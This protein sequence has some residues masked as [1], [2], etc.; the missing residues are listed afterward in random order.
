MTGSGATTGTA[1]ASSGRGGSSG[2]TGEAG[3]GGAIGTAGTSARA[4]TSG[5]T[6][7]AGTTGAAG[8]TGRAGTTGTTGTA[9]GGGTRA[10]GGSSGTAGTGAAGSRGGSGGAGATGRRERRRGHGGHDRH[11]GT[12]GTGGA[13][14][15]YRFPAGSTIYQDVSG[16]AVDSESTTILQ[17][18]QTSGW[19][20]GLGID[21]SITILTADASVPRRTFVNDGDDPDCDSAPV[22]LPAG[23]NIEGN[24]NYHCADGGDCHLL[25]YQGT[26]LYELY[27]A[28]VTTG[29]ATGGTFSGSC[30]VVWDLTRDYWQP[31]AS[32]NFSRGDHCNGADAAD[33]PM[34]A[35]TLTAA[36]VTSGELTH[37]LRFT[38]PNAH[39]RK[40]VYVHPA[41]HI[42]GPTGGADQIPYGARLR[43]K[44]SYDVNQL[45]SAA[46][47][48]IAR[49]LQK[50][51]M[52]MSDGGNLYITATTDVADVVST[53]SLR[54]LKAT[55]FE[56]VDG[57][58][59]I[60]WSDYQCH[61]TVVSN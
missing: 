21:V 52:I 9:G 5:T 37:A 53:G 56:M 11:G 17:A 49:G 23:G 32:P 10:R 8:A 48:V 44:A 60:N 43:L 3:R 55:D 7:I 45:S 57:G 36:D 4:G 46:A 13:Q 54:L 22:P 27:Q 33:L 20:S 2:T 14:G 26:R 6:G 29:G 19:G 28:D 35:L 24:D 61:R 31:V 50:Y 15:S 41:T 34:T 39:I 25:V 51:G 12:T 42:G 47:R 59:R 1:G 38:I 16:A 18:L 40:G 58:P 30:L